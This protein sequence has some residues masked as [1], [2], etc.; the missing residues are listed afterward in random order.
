MKVKTKFYI[1][2]NWYVAEAK[3]KTENIF[4]V[5]LNSGKVLAVHADT[6]LTDKINAQK[7]HV[8][9]WNAV[10]KAVELGQVS[11]VFNMYLNEGVKFIECNLQNI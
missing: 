11:G 7:S 6:S 4:C 9:L 1:F 8:S 5:E 2:D 3:G 10:K